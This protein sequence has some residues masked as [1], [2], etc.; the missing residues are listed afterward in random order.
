MIDLSKEQF[1]CKDLR[2]VAPLHTYATDEQIVLGGK[3]ILD[4][5]M[6]MSSDFTGIMVALIKRGAGGHMQGQQALLALMLTYIPAR[7]CLDCSGTGKAREPFAS[8]SCEHCL[9]TG[10]RLSPL[11]SVVPHNCSKGEASQ[12]EPRQGPA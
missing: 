7:L 8:L 6:G 3:A 9:G 11:E 4:L 5:N 2:Q 10:V 1:I 12:G